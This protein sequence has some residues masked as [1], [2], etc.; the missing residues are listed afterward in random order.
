MSDA[1]GYNPM[2]W[3]CTVRGCF[4]VKQRPKI[5]VFSDIWPGK[6]SMSD[7]DGI[8]EIRGKALV[9]EWKGAPR[10]LPTGQRIMYE[11][12]TIG[13]TITVFCVAGDAETMRVD[14]YNIFHCGKASGWMHADIETLRGRMIRWCEWAQQKQVA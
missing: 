8:V 9:L 7:I 10:T 11:R 13:G 14:A 3:D 2:K 6:I 12:L 1:N 5:E 4:N